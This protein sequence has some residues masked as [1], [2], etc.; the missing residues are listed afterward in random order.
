MPF[1]KLQIFTIHAETRQAQS[2]VPVELIVSENSPT[3]EGDE[4]VIH[5]SILQ[6]DHVGYLSFSLEI[7][8]QLDPSDDVERSLRLTPYFD[9]DQS[10]TYS[11]SILSEQTSRLIVLRVLPVENEVHRRT[12]SSIQQIDIR[13]W[14]TSPLSFG[15]RVFQSQ[16]T[17]PCAPFLSSSASA[18]LARFSQVIIDPDEEIHTLP[19]N[20]DLKSCETFQEL[21]SGV[22]NND[23]NPVDTCVRKGR[24][25]EYETT[26]KPINHGL[27]EILYSLTLAPCEQVNI[28]VI[29][30]MRDD[31]GRRAEDQTVNES[32]EHEL[33]RE[34]LL[35]EVV[36]A[37]IKEMQRGR[38]FLGGTAGTG[39]YGTQGSQGSNQ[40]GGSGSGP[41][42]GNAGAGAGS[43]AGAVSGGGNP[44][45]WGV[46]G[47]HALGIAKAR[48]S[49]TREIEAETTQTLS[50][51]ITQSGESVRQ[52]HG[53]VVVQSTQREDERINTRTIRN[54]NHCHALTVLYYEIVRHYH[55]VTRATTERDV[56]LV[57]QK[58]NPPLQSLT[59]EF[60][61][62][63]RHVFEPALIDT[64]LA[65]GFDAIEEEVYGF[66]EP[67]EDAE[68]EVGED[69]LIAV[70]KFSIEIS[71]I[72]NPQGFGIFFTLIYELT[73]D[74]QITVRTRQGIEVGWKEFDPFELT[75]PV[76]IQQIKRV[77]LGIRID[78][79]FKNQSFELDALRVEYTTDMDNSGVLYDSEAFNS[80]LFPKLMGAGGSPNSWGDT[81]S[82]RRETVK[83][84]N[85]PSGIDLA[86][87]LMDHIASNYFHYQKALWLAKD[88]DERIASL[89]GYLWPFEESVAAD[90]SP[91]RLTDY[92][93]RDPIG[94][95]GDWLIFLAGSARAITG[96]TRQVSETGGQYD[97]RNT[98]AARREYVPSQVEYTYTPPPEPVETVI[99]LP[100]RGAYAESK[101]A[102][103]N[104]CEV[105]DST[106]FWRWQES[107][108]PDNAPE[109]SP[110]EAGS[111]AQTPLDTSLSELPSSVIN[112]QNAPAAPNP[113]GLAAALDLLGRPDIFRDLTGLD[114]LGPLLQKLADVAAGTSSGI[115]SNVRDAHE[116]NQLLRDA[117][118]RGEITPEERNQGIAENIRNI[119]RQSSEEETQN[120]PPRRSPERDNGGAPRDQEPSDN[121][122]LDTS[123]QPLDRISLRFQRSFEIRSRDSGVGV[124]GSTGGSAGGSISTADVPVTLTGI[125][126]VRGFVGNIQSTPS[127]R[128]AILAEGYGD[129]LDGFISLGG[130]DEDLIDIDLDNW[131][132]PSGL[133]GTQFRIR[134]QFERIESGGNLRIDIPQLGA[135]LN[136][137]ANFS[138]DGE[139]LATGY[140][141]NLRGTLSNGQ[142]IREQNTP[143][144]GG[145]ED[146]P[147]IP[148]SMLDSE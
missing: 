87:M 132:L 118:Q 83:A 88:P 4:I 142:Q 33:R 42:G 126:I 43:A 128:Y 46:F 57:K 107:P 26:W 111:R 27:G 15:T 106:R 25:V 72:E 76:Q 70:L 31:Q 140:E 77:G 69:E 130:R 135:R 65:E 133:N 5:R 67:I 103:C 50:D 32:L 85:M 115:L 141:F 61:A 35:E 58:I 63:N 147:G 34:R 55:V 52:L 82:V 36:E 47:S 144:Y 28:A 92:I 121:D 95:Y 104:S 94:V 9:T 16:N 10:A 49:G 124:S 138:G 139:F 19:R 13:D 3:G 116:R 74:S 7:L 51:V 148:G 18:S 86:T 22:G 146:Y 29:D 21:T 2:D 129:A 91:N 78:P 68:A 93:E 98:A 54:Y 108:C 60:V 123:N 56:I 64:R 24:L 143:E 30:W 84:T 112:I 6:S 127:Y 134:G 71:N 102:E 38:S 100:T 110:I 105:I 90:G 17:G 131:T 1:P 97:Y 122:N 20:D 48:T 89:E 113:S 79:R 39:G 37:T 8:T 137:R 44:F 41:S 81:M 40:S 99:A 45:S 145:D 114:Q 101:L 66:P 53:T 120:P 14:K 80:R 136:K 23:V 96:E 75:Q 62:K 73:D 117:E 11:P 12:Y 125:V 59:R 119:P 109:I